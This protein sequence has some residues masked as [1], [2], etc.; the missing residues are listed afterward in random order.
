MDS[1]KLYYIDKKDY[2]YTYVGESFEKA[3]DDPIIWSKIKNTVQLT[4]WFFDGSSISPSQEVIMEICET[5]SEE[6]DVTV[7]LDVKQYRSNDK[8]LS[9][10]GLYIEEDIEVGRQYAEVRQYLVDKFRDVNSRYKIDLSG[11]VKK[12]GS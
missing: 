6:F 9:L 10:I 4:D 7:Y 8:E 5:L 12:T 2:E 11:H 1:E 3:A